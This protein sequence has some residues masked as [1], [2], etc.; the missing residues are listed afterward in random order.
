M[1][2][3]AKKLLDKKD[4]DNPEFP[5]APYRADEKEDKVAPKE[6]DTD[7]PLPKKKG[8][9][10]ADPK[11]DKADPKDAKE[12]KDDEDEKKFMPRLGGKK[13]KIDPRYKGKQRPTKKKEKGEADD[14]EDKEA[15]QQNQNSKDADSAEKALKSDEQSLDDL[16]SQL[17][18]KAGKGKPKTGEPGDDESDPLADQLRAMMQSKSMRDAMAMAAAAK[19]KPK[20]KPQA[21]QPPPPPTNRDTGNLDG[22]ERSDGRRARWASST[23]RPALHDP[24]D[25]PVEVPRRTHPRPQ[26]AGA[27]GVPRAFIQNYFKQLTEKRAKK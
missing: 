5:D 22:G 26:R 14:K 6:A 17:T 1:L 11:G 10:K 4:K 27:G 8:K 13:E 2:A 12:E 7:E 20:G 18:S 23:P 16:I 15:D 24:Q 21:N 25:A 19:S 9:E 3:K